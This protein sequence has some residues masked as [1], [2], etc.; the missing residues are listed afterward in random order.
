MTSNQK[1]IINTIGEYGC[2]CGDYNDGETIIQAHCHRTYYGNGTKDK[3][4]CPYA[5]IH[6]KGKLA[7]AKRIA[8]EIEEGYRCDVKIVKL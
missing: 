5:G 7:T 4:D 8:K 2:A 3:C 6:Y 1:K